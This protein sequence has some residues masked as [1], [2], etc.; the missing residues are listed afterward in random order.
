[1]TLRSRIVGGLLPLVLA[2][3]PGC[4]VQDS[5]QPPVGS[6]SVPAGRD[7]GGVT[8]T[9]KAARPKPAPK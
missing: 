5:T 9:G 6:I 4:G 2:A 1:M 3:S 8:I 7:D